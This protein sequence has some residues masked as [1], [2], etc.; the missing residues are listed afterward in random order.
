M[1]YKHPEAFCLMEY[2]CGKCGGMEILW[3]SRDGVTPFQINCQICGD[4]MS[5]VHP[6][7]DICAPSFGTE[8]MG[9]RY[10]KMRLFVPITRV[11]ADEYARHRLSWAKEASGAVVPESDTDDYKQIHQAISDDI[12]HNGEAPD[13]IPGQEWFLMPAPPIGK[14]S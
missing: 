10:S 13:V 9:P 2:Q 7:H 14:V 3:N 4:R 8:A 1:S 5:H 6:S 12:Y 11:K